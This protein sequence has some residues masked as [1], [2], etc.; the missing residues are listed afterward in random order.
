MLYEE[1]KE[2]TKGECTYDEYKVV[3]AAYTES[4]TMTKTEAASLWR[5]LYGKAHRE[6]KKEAKIKSHSLAYIDELTKNAV[7][8]QR[9]ILPNGDEIKVRLD[10][11]NWQDRFIFRAGINRDGYPELT[12]IALDQYG[13]LRPHKDNPYK[14]TA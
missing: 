6:A 5:F 1:L 2:L 14:L 12:C 9:F 10:N 11:Q 4:D 13:K 8:G 3:N 7:S